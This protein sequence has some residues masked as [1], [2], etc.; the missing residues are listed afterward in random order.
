MPS[1]RPARSRRRRILFLGCALLLLWLCA[2]ILAFVVYWVGFGERFS[3]ARHAELRTE[4]T[5]A[6]Q[7]A[8]QQRRTA[9]SINW[10]LHPY[11]GYVMD[12]EDA[13][14]SRPPGSLLPISSHGFLD[15][16]PPRR[17]RG[18]DELH[19]AILGGSVAQHF[20]EFGAPT[21]AAALREQPGLAHLRIVFVR[22]ALPGYRQPQQVLAL[23]Y[24]LAQGARFDA[25]LDL[26]G[27]NELAEPVQKDAEGVVHPDFPSNWQFLAAQSLEPATQRAIGGAT[28]LR[29]LRA[30]LA[31]WTDLPILRWSPLCGLAWRSADRALEARQTRFAAEAA[32]RGDLVSFGIRGPSV[33]SLGFDAALDYGAELWQRGA[34]LI[35][36]RAESIGAKAFFFLQ[37]N[38]YVDGGKPLSATE[39]RDAFRT[40]HPSR[41]IVMDGFPRLRVRG[42]QLAQEGVAFFDLSKVFAD[43]AETL[44]LDPCCHLNERGNQLL[45][46]AVARILGPSLA[47]DRTPFPR[48]LVRG[49]RADP[50][51][52]RLS[53]MF[54]ATRIE[55]IADLADGSSRHA[56]FACRD[57]ASEDSRVVEVDAYGVLTALREGS[58]AIR[59]TLAGHSVRVPV[60]VAFPPQH[61]LDSPSPRR[62]DPAL[63]VT[64]S[65]T[66]LTIGLDRDAP[67][68]IESAWLL[69]GTEPYRSP[70]CREMLY[71]DARANPPRIVAR[72]GERFAWSVPIEPALRGRAICLQA[73][74][75]DPRLPCGVRVT[76]AVVV[77][78]P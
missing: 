4:L 5:D 51:S 54:A 74:L 16:G 23:D 2:E 46:S 56:S 52:I 63:V 40:D 41:R 24:A 53:A 32:R 37:P 11:L 15:D 9:T 50:S 43:V 1:D 20:A 27:L 75:L 45:A 48:D 65:E 28:F 70:Y 55:I 47:L 22:L 7:Q 36:Q 60:T 72:S 25:I 66:D 76:D 31:H 3:P 34:R 67:A 10:S 69:I 61:A 19:V 13:S 33:E 73:G 77:R 64:S 26:S 42:E 14:A 59:A 8:L 78:L 17:L 44:Y 12:P 71:V 49:L 18:P 57:Y 38:Q 35:H 30:N 6:S 58:T 21:L 29:D 39:R 68:G 62:D